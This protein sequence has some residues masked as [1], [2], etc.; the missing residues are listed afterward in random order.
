MNKVNIIG[1]AL[2]LTT[3][4][5]HAQYAIPKSADIASFKKLA[6]QTVTHAEASLKKIAKA[7]ATADPAEMRREVETPARELQKSW[8]GFGFSDRVMLEYSA[9]TNLLSEL[10]VYAL[11]A[12]RAPRFH[13]GDFAQKKLNDIQADLGECRKLI[14]EAPKFES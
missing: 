12:R 6:A 10:P 4:A 9:C 14:K 2:L 7:G 11:E 8:A 3:A 13:L 1:A 5:A